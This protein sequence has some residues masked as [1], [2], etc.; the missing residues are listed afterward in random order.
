MFQQISVSCYFYL[1]LYL[2]GA[3]HSQY[4]ESFLLGQNKKRNILWSVSVFFGFP[5]NIRPNK[6]CFGELNLFFF[7]YKVSLIW[8]SVYLQDSCN[9]LRL[10]FYRSFKESLLDFLFIRYYLFILEKKKI[11]VWLS[12][13]SFKEFASALYKL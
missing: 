6:Y 12:R 1:A 2:Y 13:E 10:H 3:I 7:M 5:G 8:H 4:C 11:K 9:L